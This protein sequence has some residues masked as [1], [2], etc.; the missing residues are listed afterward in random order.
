MDWGILKVKALQYTAGPHS[1]I[2][3]ALTTFCYSSK[4]DSHF[5]G[6]GIDYHETATC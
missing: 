4:G 5:R 2:A 6:I 1:R 3:K